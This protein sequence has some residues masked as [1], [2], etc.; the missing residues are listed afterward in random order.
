[1]E[2]W[3]LEDG[4]RLNWNRP[5][6]KYSVLEFPL[7]CSRI[8]ISAGVSAAPG[9]RFNPRPGQW[10]KGSNVAAAAAQVTLRL[11]S[12]P[13]PWEFR[14]LQGDQKRKRKKTFL[15]AMYRKASL[16]HCKIIMINVS[17][18]VIVNSQKNTLGD[19]NKYVF[20]RVLWPLLG[21]SPI[22]NCMNNKETYWL[23]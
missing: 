8:G 22:Q 18:K 11:G 13:W 17:Q 20:I 14:M 1:M 19:F 15:K 2:D 5:G 23:T 4:F 21:K 9:Y 12:D 7:W 3:K 16:Q 10:V 6:E